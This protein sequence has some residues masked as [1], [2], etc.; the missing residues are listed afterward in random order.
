MRQHRVPVNGP[1][2]Y[3]DLGFNQVTDREAFL[4]AQKVCEP[5][6]PPSKAISIDEILRFHQYQAKLMACVQSSPGPSAQSACRAK[7]GPAP[8]IH[9]PKASRS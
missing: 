7:L 1:D 6:W 8:E 2:S 9:G 4:A 3:G 5:L